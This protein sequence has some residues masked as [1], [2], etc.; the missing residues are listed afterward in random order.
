MKR[1]GPKRAGDRRRRLWKAG[2][3]DRRPRLTCQSHRSPASYNN[4]HSRLP[5]SPFPSASPLLIVG[6]LRARRPRPCR[7]TRVPRESPS[8]PLFLPC[9]TALPQKAHQDHRYASSPLP[10]CASL[11]VPLVVAADGLSKREVFRL[12]DPFAVITVDAEQTHT[13]SVMKKTLNPYWNES[14]D[15]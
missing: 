11:I 4:H 8:F 2:E 10:L 5:P 3:V 13:T 7:Q 12:P 14:F 6:R 1:N 15:M 9:L